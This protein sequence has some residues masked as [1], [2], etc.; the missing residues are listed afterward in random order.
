MACFVY[1]FIRRRAVDARTLWSL[2]VCTQS[3]LVIFCRDF[4][5]IFW[6]GF[7]FFFF[8]ART[9]YVCFC[10]FYVCFCRFCFVPFFFSLFFNYYFIFILLLHGKQA[11][12]EKK[13]RLRSVSRMFKRIGSQMDASATSGDESDSNRLV[14]FSS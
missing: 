5:D 2:Y 1:C 9:L 4:L 12:A 10:V 7:F 3:N 14:R 11:V 13:K 8:C 6:G